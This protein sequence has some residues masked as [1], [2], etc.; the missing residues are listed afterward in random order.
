MNNLNL[1]IKWLPKKLLNI[2][3]FGQIQLYKRYKFIKIKLGSDLDRFFS[4]CSYYGV[5]NFRD[6]LLYASGIYNFFSFNHFFL[7][8][9]CM[10]VK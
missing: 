3:M 2:L 1:E 8:L 6:G 10:N 5:R 9:R 4:F 7:K